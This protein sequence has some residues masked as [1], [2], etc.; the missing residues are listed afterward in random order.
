M[1][2]KLTWNMNRSEFPASP[3]KK[4]RAMVAGGTD[5]TGHQNFPWG[6]GGH[7]PW[8]FLKTRRVAEAEE[9]GKWKSPDI[10]SAVYRT[11]LLDKG[12]LKRNQAGGEVETFVRVLGWWFGKA[13]IYNPHLIPIWKTTTKTKFRTT[14]LRSD[15]RGGKHRLVKLQSHTVSSTAKGG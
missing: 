6:H 15:Q 12:G 11:S 3:E 10:K 2:P 9:E 14:S 5:S 7:T 13:S 4:E 1:I 8:V